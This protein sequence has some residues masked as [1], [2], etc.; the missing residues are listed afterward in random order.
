VVIAGLTL[1]ALCLEVAATIKT[2]SIA[3]GQINALCNPGCWSGVGGFA[4]CGIDC[5]TWDCKDG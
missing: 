5:K 2:N 3:L 4:S 1:A